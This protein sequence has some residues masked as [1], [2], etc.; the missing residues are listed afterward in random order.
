MLLKLTQDHCALMTYRHRRTSQGGWRDCSPPDYGKT[1]IFLTKAKFL[2]QK[3][4]AKNEKY[5]FFVF[6][7]RK[8]GI[9]SG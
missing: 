3:P 7:K 1:I 8:N 4:A 2:G 5:I 6:I 9:L